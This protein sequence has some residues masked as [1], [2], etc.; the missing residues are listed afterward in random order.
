MLWASPPPP[1]SNAPGCLE[2]FSVFSA[3][4]H[5]TNI[6]FCLQLNYSNGIIESAAPSCGVLGICQWHL[7]SIKNLNLRNN[8]K[9][10]N[11]QNE[12]NRHTLKHINSKRPSPTPFHDKRLDDSSVCSK[13]AFEVSAIRSG[14]PTKKPDT[15]FL[16]VAAPLEVQ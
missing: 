14:G 7:Y 13:S 15:V 3:Y 5:R 6:R 1:P 4:V 11:K 2:T 9:I 10:I 12:A 16:P 8:R